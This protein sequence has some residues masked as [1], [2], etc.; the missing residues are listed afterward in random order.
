MSVY[1]V[2]H[3]SILWIICDN[4]EEISSHRDQGSDNSPSGSRFYER[5]RG[6]RCSDRWPATDRLTGGR[7]QSTV[8]CS[9][10]GSG[11]PHPL[12]YLLPLP[13][14]FW[15]SLWQHL[16][17]YQQSEKWQENNKKLWYFMQSMILHIINDITCNQWYYR[18]FHDL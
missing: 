6:S 4:N 10:T 1:S 5:F 11:W 14:P 7:R 13:I 8:M 2:Y 9:G 18:A 12:C 16:Y 15:L 17:K 3:F